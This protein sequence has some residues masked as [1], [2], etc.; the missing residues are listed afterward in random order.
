MTEE[1]SCMSAFDNQAIDNHAIARLKRGDPAGLEALVR[2]YQLR[3]VQTAYLIVRDRA[4]AEDL[5]QSAFIHA[6]EKI[7]QFDDRRPFGPW[8]LRSVVHAALKAAKKQQRLVSLEADPHNLGNPLAD[9]LADPSPC[10]EAMVESAETRQAVWQALGR[11][12]P[13]Q[14]AAI[15]MRY[16]LDLSEAEMTSRL[17]R[18][19]S[20]VKW[21][22][23]A[24]R[25]RLRSLLHL[26]K[27]VSDPDEE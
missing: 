16:F 8:F 7:A 17:H 3:A 6:A 22:L 9:L 14:R 5:V 24:A 19:S 2:C 18:P 26:W 11:L 15:V 13:E 10:P 21:W 23:H 25:D 27:P 20:T 1:S 4:L 12:T